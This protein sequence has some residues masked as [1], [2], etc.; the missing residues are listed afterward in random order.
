MTWNY[1]TSNLATYVARIKTKLY[2][3]LKKED[4]GYVLLQDG[5]RIIVDITYKNK[6]SNTTS[7][8][9]K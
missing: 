3:F 5:G 1:K 2:G 9:Y 8:T 4:D 7:W 6:S